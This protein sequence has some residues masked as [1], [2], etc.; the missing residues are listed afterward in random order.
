MT[1]GP[2]APVP[3]QLCPKWLWSLRAAVAAARFSDPRAT[4]YLTQVLI[5][6]RDKLV[7]AW[8]PSPAPDGQTR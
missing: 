5:K 3:V 2:A 4:E 6:R 1:V 8:L 7:R